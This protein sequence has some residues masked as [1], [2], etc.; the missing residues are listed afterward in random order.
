MPSRPGSMDNVGSSARN[1]ARAV[2]AGLQSLDCGHEAC[3]P[4]VV[5]V[6]LVKPNVCV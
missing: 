1:G 5:W 4:W 3:A 2:P 6:R